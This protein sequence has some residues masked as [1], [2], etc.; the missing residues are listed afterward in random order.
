MSLQGAQG[1]ERQP[2]LPAF[3]LRALP[4][5]VG[6]VGWRLAFQSRTGG[7]GRGGGRGAAG[8][9]EAR[10]PERLP[11]QKPGATGQLA[12]RAA[13][14]GSYPPGKQTKNFPATDVRRANSTIRAGPKRRHNGGNSKR[15]KQ[16]PVDLRLRRF[17]GFYRVP[18]LH[19]LP[20]STSGNGKTTG[21]ATRS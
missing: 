18:V 4:L 1:R 13:E 21:S 16:A 7:R 12:A 8:T 15:Y 20:P 3:Q 11:L 6:L 17:C 19:K 2:S 9:Y 14:G 10:R 5:P